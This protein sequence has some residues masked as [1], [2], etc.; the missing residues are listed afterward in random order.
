MTLKGHYLP[1][2]QGNILI[3]DLSIDVFVRWADTFT[4]DVFGVLKNENDPEPGMTQYRRRGPS[5]V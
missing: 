4:P 5:L 3:V 1:I 2:L